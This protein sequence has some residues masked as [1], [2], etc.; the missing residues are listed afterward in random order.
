MFIS[1]H[2]QGLYAGGQAGVNLTKHRGQKSDHVFEVST[3]YGYPFYGRGDRQCS[4]C[5][6][7]QISMLMARRGATAAPGQIRLAFA[8]D[9]TLSFL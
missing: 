6:G 3:T 8:A 5:G 7:A 2:I 1:S 4:R 9:C